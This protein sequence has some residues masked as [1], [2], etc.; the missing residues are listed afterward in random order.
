MFKDDVFN[1]MAK[2]A[3]TQVYRLARLVLPKQDSKMIAETF[4]AIENMGERKEMV[5][6]IW[7][8][9]AEARGLNLTEAGQKIVN[10]TITK[11]DSKFSVANF[12]DDFQDI[13]ALP[14]DFNPFMTTPSL[15]DIDRAAARSGLISRLWG[16]SNKEWVDKMTGYWSFLTL[17]GPRYAI[18][19][20]SEDLMV[21]LAIGGSP[22]GLA[23]NRYLSTR[24]NTAIE[25]ARASKNW[26]DNPLGGMLRILNKKE[27]A[28][29]E[30]QIAGI[31]DAIVNA[32]EEIKAIREQIKI[33]TDPAAKVSLE[34]KIDELKSVTTVSATEQTRR[35]MATALTSGRINRYRKALGMK[36]MFEEEAGILQSILSTET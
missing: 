35:I 15:V 29:F 19:N 14:S 22:W 32:R 13:G 36:P 8:T 3:S 30:T 17:A 27:A 28:K 12:A 2:D 26:S 1:V 23:K 11:G 33:T 31:D 20:A 10:Q 5:K 21:H 9:I 25:G 6:G 24:V 18:R 34:T 16:Q 7:G 4:E